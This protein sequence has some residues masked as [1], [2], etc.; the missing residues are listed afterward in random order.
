MGWKNN[1]TSRKLSWRHNARPSLDLQP[2][3]EFLY[4][5]SNILLTRFLKRIS[6]DVLYPKDSQHMIRM[7]FLSDLRTLIITKIIF[8]LI[9]KQESQDGNEEF[10][11]SGRRGRRRLARACQARPEPNCAPLVRSPIRP[12]HWGFGS[13]SW[14]RDN[15]IET[16][17]R[18]GPN[19]REYIIRVEFRPPRNFVD[20]QR[21]QDLVSSELCLDKVFLDHR[22]KEFNAFKMIYN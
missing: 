5:S 16:N 10:E 11:N 2:V 22:F 7:A 8:S 4:S 1:L 20:V 3:D 6:I 13:S 19:S 14:R 17:L 15:I 21:R 9:I 18:I 12:I